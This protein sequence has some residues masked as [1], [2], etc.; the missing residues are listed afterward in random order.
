MAIQ[1]NIVSVVLILWL[2]HKEVH[3]NWFQVN[4]I[5][6]RPHVMIIMTYCIVHLD[7]MITHPLYMYKL[8]LSFRCW[9]CCLIPFCVDGCKDVI[10]SCPN[11][12]QTMGRFNR[13]WSRGRQAVGSRC[14]S[15]QGEADA[16]VKKKGQISLQVLRDFIQRIFSF[17][18]N[19]NINI[20]TMCNICLCILH[21]F[22]F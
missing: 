1:V 15:Q 3:D 2:T 6:C 12:H 17:I 19:K 7:D 10:H 16:K 18:M 22:F 9:P 4:I 21:I 8:L 14:Q 20:K 5:S 13:M 11:C